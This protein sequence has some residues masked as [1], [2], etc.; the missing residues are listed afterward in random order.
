MSKGFGVGVK[1]TAFWTASQN[2]FEAEEKL[3]NLTEKDK[4]DIID[5]LV[6]KKELT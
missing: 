1:I 4:Q 2:I 5:Y 3:V 6:E